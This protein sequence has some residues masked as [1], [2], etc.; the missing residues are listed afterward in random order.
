LKHDSEK[1]RP[2]PILILAHPTVLAAWRNVGLSRASCR[3]LAILFLSASERRGA[4]PHLLPALLS[5]PHSALSPPEPPP[6]FAFGAEALLFDFGLA[7]D[8]GLVV[9]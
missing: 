5:S 3:W 9:L 6:L 7:F 2:T 8:P 4:Y 1:Q